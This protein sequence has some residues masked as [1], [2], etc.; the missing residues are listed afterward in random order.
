MAKEAGWIK[1][2][3]SVTE[4]WLYTEKRIFSRFEAWNDI[5]L[6]VN[7]AETQCCIKGKVYTV[8]RGESILSFDSWGKRWGWDKSKVRRFFSLLKSDNMIELKSD[9]ITT[10]LTVCKYD[11]Y[12]D[13]GNTDETPTKHERNSNEYQTTPIEEGKK[14]RKEE[15]KNKFN[16]KFFLLNYGFEESLV[17]DWIIVRKSKKAANT[18]TAFKNFISELEKRPCDKNEILKTIVTK[19]WSGF[20]WEWIDNISKPQPQANNNQPQ[21]LKTRYKVHG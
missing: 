19:S 10:H 14:E 2:H 20:K 18:E 15:G 3:R 7:F 21:Q 6:T 5:L 12:Q 8:K 9:N 13:N 4:H 16:F 1:L 17:N 11:T